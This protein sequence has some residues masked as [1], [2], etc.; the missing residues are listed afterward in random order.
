M[1]ST[2]I[3]VTTNN[4]VFCLKFIYHDQSVQCVSVN[5]LFIHRNMYILYVYVENKRIYFVQV[6]SYC[7]ACHKLADEIYCSYCCRVFH[8][9]CLKKL[10]L[11]DIVNFGCECKFSTLNGRESPLWNERGLG[12]LLH[13]AFVES[14]TEKK[15]VSMLCIL[16]IYFKNIFSY[17]SVKIPVILFFLQ[18]VQYKN[19]CYKIFHLVLQVRPRRVPG[20]C[21]NFSDRS[22]EI[23]KLSKLISARKLLSY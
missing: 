7:W 16:Q 12:E 17:F 11:K 15:N 21:H 18:N 2:I 14:L 9:N 10:K 6:D 13:L 4:V 19:L 22:S 1:C 5:V 3:K 8:T 20:S 23:I